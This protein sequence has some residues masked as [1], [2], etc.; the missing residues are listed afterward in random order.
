MFDVYLCVTT[1]HDWRMLAAAL[2]VC[3]IASAATFFLSAKAS[4]GDGPRRVAWLALL[5]LV[6]GSAIWTTHM[7]G[8]IAFEPGLPENYEP[9]G[10]FGSFGVAVAASILGFAIASRPSQDRSGQR[11][12]TLAQRTVGGAVIGL[13]ISAMHYLGMAAYHT[14]GQVNWRPSYVAAS[15][16]LGVVLSVAALL[17]APPAARPRRQALGALLFGL[18]ICAMHFTAMAAARLTPDPT[19]VLPPSLMSE[20]MMAALAVAVNLTITAAGLGVTTFDILTRNRDLNRLRDALEAMPDGLAL[21]DSDDRL[22]TWN[23]RYAS[24]RQGLPLYRGQT[25]TEIL[26]QGLDADRFVS[27]DLDK[28]AWVAERVRI[29]RDGVSI[30]VHTAKG[31]WLRCTDRRTADG[32]MVTVFSDITDLKRAEEAMV[33]AHDLA[34][35]ASRIKSEFLANMSHEIRTPMNGILGMNALLLMTSLTPAQTRYA[36]VVQGSAEGLMA[37][38][39]DILDVA[40]LEAGAVEMASIDF[41]LAALLRAVE[42][43]HRPGALAKGLELALVLDQKDWPRLMGDPGRLR[44]V[45]AHLVANAVKFTDAGRVT[46]AVRGRAEGGAR[47]FV[48]IEVADTGAGVAPEL[49]PALFEPFRQGDGGATRRHG[50]AGLGLAICRHAVRLM[51]GAIGVSDREGGGSVFWVELSLPEAPAAEAVAA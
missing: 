35:E 5:G 46:L 15:I 2:A 10:A 49:R 42:A 51:G 45:L 41:D 26:H 39:N 28:A 32:G 27:P 34:Q 33:Q 40:K 20:E 14:E 19:I 17:A 23:G 37:I 29:R 44:Q 3:A 13:G 48:R 30:D 18:G 31:H 47:T 24:L 38:F 11:G 36:E 50:G 1:Q 22:Q 25:Y 16:I 12:S 7:L 8:M 21:F 6:A 9:A 43:E 4:L